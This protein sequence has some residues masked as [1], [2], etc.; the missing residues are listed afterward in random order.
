MA[1]VHREIAEGRPIGKATGPL[2]SRGRDAHSPERSR[3]EFL[4]GVGVAG[5][6]GRPFGCKAVAFFV[7]LLYQSSVIYWYIY[8]YCYY[9]NE[10]TQQ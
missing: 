10:G 4:D 8:T 9:C 7:L 2:P 3:E 5:F 1:C 6:F